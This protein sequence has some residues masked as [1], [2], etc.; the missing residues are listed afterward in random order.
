[1]VE[2]FMA[3]GLAEFDEELFWPI[4]NDGIMVGGSSRA[5]QS[6][7]SLCL[8]H[9]QQAAKQNEQWESWEASFQLADHLKV[10]PSETPLQQRC[11]SCHVTDAGK[12]GSEIPK[13]AFDQPE[14]FSGSCSAMATS[15]EP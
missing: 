8:P 6:A 9:L 5:M 3:V 10:H 1:M 13:I 7:Q 2:P 12:P 4:A 11:V 14:V 15:A